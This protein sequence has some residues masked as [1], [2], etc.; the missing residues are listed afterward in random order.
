MRDDE[1]KK[2]KIK[3]KKKKKKNKPTQG[4]EEMGSPHQ[5]FQQLAH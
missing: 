3:R 1:K 4:K 2:K 5:A